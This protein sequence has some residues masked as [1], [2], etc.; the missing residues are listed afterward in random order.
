[1]RMKRLAAI[2]M[3]STAVCHASLIFDNIAGTAIPFAT[4][5]EVHQVILPAGYTFSFEGAPVHSVFVTSS[6]FVWLEN[7]NTSQCCTLAPQ[8]AVENLIATNPARIMPAWTALR[9]DVGGTVSYAQVTDTQGARTDVTF[10][11]VATD[12]NN[13]H[14]TTFQLQL[15]TSGMIVFSYPDF[16]SSDFQSVQAVILGL[17]GVNPSSPVAVDF[18]QVP[19]TIG[20]SVYD[21][22]STSGPAFNLTN[23]SLVFTPLQAGG[24]QVGTTLTPEPSTFL[25]GAAGIFALALIRSRQKRMN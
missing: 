2:L 14:Q 6:G 9:P 12:F 13:L 11:N 5:D 3:F 7:P 1:M 10:S 15:Y 22:L 17:T 23:Q 25:P 19:M 16:V 8:S 20:N 4:S 18:T 24:F 21:Y